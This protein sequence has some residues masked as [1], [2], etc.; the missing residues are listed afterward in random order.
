MSQDDSIPESGAPEGTRS[1]TS[2]R[3]ARSAP[4]ARRGSGTLA[5]ALLISLVAAGGAGYVGWR[6]W[7][8]EQG[9]VA[10]HAATDA[11]KQRV[12]TLE[13]AFSASDSERNLL[14]QRLGDA[15]QVNRSL[16]EE[17][18]GQAERMRNLEDAVAK[19]SEKTLSGHDA[20]LLDETESL[21][22]M[23]KERY[24]LFHDAQG[25]LDAYA[26]ADQALAAVNDD[27]FSG[28][29]QSIGAEREALT[30]S[31][32]GNLDTSLSTL[33]HLRA[34]MTELP[35]KPLD[36]TANDTSG[37][38][39]SRIMGALNNVVKVQRTNGAP[40]SVA[41]A[42][43][44]R[45]LTAIDLAQAQA[46]LLASDRDAYIAALKRADAGLAGQF[47][48]AA[49]PVQQAREQLASLIAQAPGAPVQLGAAL[50]ELRNLRAVHALKP[51]SSS[52]VGARP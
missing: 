18:L 15:D 37:S 28:L 40:L 24:D 48:E 25:A 27:A 23:A 11:L 39:W 47:D 21:L 8:Q 16:R 1:D 9:S 26:L 34:S 32:A 2:S 33:S 51:A 3:P 22:R 41:D 19:L 12:D 6:Q 31:K 4:P 29:R 5:V 30:K 10:N 20:M 44:A 49:A 46:A 36:S 7:Q 52:S 35:L 43:F 13:S 42:R 14:R 45:E 38:G 17:V 50:G